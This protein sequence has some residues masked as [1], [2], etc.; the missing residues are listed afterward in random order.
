MRQRQ[1]RLRLREDRIG[2]PEIMDWLESL[3]K[4]S[5]GAKDLNDQVI[6][7]LGRAIRRPRKRSQS[8]AKTLPVAS[9]RANGGGRQGA[10]ERPETMPGRPATGLEKRKDTFNKES[11]QDPLAIAASRMDF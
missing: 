10:E 1:L 5:R 8:T 6:S 3:E 9:S 2:H 11:G 7:A 4:D